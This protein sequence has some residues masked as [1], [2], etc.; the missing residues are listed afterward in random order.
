M[1][2]SSDALSN[3]DG[4]LGLAFPTISSNPGVPT[5]LANL[6]SADKGMFAFYL[7]DEADGELAVGGYD[8]DQMQGNV[9]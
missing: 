6:A 1:N 7:G 5:V 3:F 4:I 8:D 9:N 2:D